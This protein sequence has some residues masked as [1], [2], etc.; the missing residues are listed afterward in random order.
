MLETIAAAREKRL[1]DVEA[2]LAK[3]FGKKLAADIHTVHELEEH[4]PIETLWDVTTAVTAV[5]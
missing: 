3:R 1:D 4:R 5:A 2:F